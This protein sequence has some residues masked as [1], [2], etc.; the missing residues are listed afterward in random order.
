[1]H[2]ILA[3]M[4]LL[5]IVPAVVGAPITLEMASPL[6]RSSKV[7]DLDQTPRG[8]IPLSVGALSSMWNA[9]SVRL[10][11][12]PMPDGSEATL[13]LERRDSPIES[14]WLIG[15]DT[16]GNE[17]RRHIPAAPVLLLAGTVDGDPDS[18]VFLGLADG[19]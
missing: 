14:T 12:M 11:G 9:T 10:N 15:S 19:Q 6:S 5:A 17:I 4:G 7:A 13:V 16:A 18:A 8:A 1:M 2:R 3:F